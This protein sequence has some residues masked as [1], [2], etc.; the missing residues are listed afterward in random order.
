MSALISLKKANKSFKTV[1][2][3]SDVSLT[4][5][6]GEVIALVGPNGS[7][8]TSLIRSIIGLL[9]FDNPLAQK[10]FNQPVPVSL[11]SRKDIMYIPDD[12]NLIDDISATEYFGLVAY[13]YNVPA[14]HIEGA[15]RQLRRLDFDIGRVDK[16]IRTY[17][18]GMRKKVQLAAL[19][20]GQPKLIIIDEPTN[21]LDP[22]AIILLKHFIRRLIS[23]LT[24][25]ILSTHNLAF[26]EK[27]AKRVVMLSNKVVY[28]G[29]LSTLLSV[30]T[31]HNLEEAYSL[32]VLK[33]DSANLTEP[34]VGV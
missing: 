23:P 33:E 34:V 20:I 5:H 24:T 14:F 19:A 8:K 18:H 32:F 31:T 22:T 30:T 7:G 13:S 6:Q 29:R 12:D 25:V 28:D 2:A 9:S 1:C 15:L 16:L 26:A 10:V 17:S 27:L 3:F 11:A 4:V 21:G